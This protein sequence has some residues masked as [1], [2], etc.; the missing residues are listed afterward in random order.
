MALSAMS[1]KPPPF[2]A[3]CSEILEVIAQRPHAFVTD[4]EVLQELLHRHLSLRLWPLAPDPIFSQPQTLC[5]VFWR[6]RQP[7]RS[8]WSREGVEVPMGR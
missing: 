2:K 4:A 1:G 7:P 6:S 5:H 8:W 3:R